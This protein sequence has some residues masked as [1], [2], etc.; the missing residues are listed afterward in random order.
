MQDK[1]AHE[2]SNFS[3]RSSRLMKTKTCCNR[4]LL[5][6]RNPSHSP[7]QILISLALIL[8][9]FHF[10]SSNHK[11]PLRIPVG[12]ILP[13][14][15]QDTFSA[16]DAHR[17]DVLRTKIAQEVPLPGGD[18]I[19][20]GSILQG[21]VVAIMPDNDEVGVR[22]T[23]RFNQLIERDQTTSL[24]TS[25]RA[26]ASYPAV[27]DAQTPLTGSGG[28]TPA[29]WATTV[30]IGDDIRYGDGALVRNR[31]KQKVG[32]GVLGGVLVHVK[33]NPEMGCSG[34]VGEDAPQALWVFSADACGVYG[35][36]GVTIIRVPGHHPGEFILH[37]KKKDMK[38]SSG[39]ALLLASSPRIDSQSQ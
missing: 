39:S 37:F 14:Q 8:S 20:F 28:G 1:I 17:G 26:I 25:L 38:L 23:L 29:G 12:Y 5:D 35:L 30:Q 7:R 21:T 11:T 15:L 18:K 13:V 2:P 4:N 32:E 3:Y 36:R 6:A 33:A 24:A 19:K 27:R 10:P 16:E 22:V 31:Q 9:G 34:P